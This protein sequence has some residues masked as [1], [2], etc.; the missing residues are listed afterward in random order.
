MRSNTTHFAPITELLKIHKDFIS[1]VSNNSVNILFHL[2]EQELAFTP[3]EHLIKDIDLSAICL[4]I[5]DYRA[6]PQKAMKLA[7]NALDIDPDS[8]SKTQDILAKKYR[9]LLF[10]DNRRIYV[11]PHGYVSNVFLT[12]HGRIQHLSRISIANMMS[13]LSTM[14]HSA[15]YEVDPIYA[16]TYMLFVVDNYLDMLRDSSIDIA[17]IYCKLLCDHACCENDKQAIT[18]KCSSSELPFNPQALERIGKLGTKL[19][20]LDNYEEIIRRCLDYK[21]DIFGSSADIESYRCEISN[22]SSP[23]RLDD[24]DKQYVDTFNKCLR[25]ISC[26][27][28]LRERQVGDLSKLCIFSQND[29][30]E[31]TFFSLQP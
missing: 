5:H 27:V 20:S 23:Y 3:A 9:C 10:R 18:L 8:R 7:Q 1:I 14:I 12:D 13:N 28:A 31:D 19:E 11:Q 16:D 26:M 15:Y 21:P 30:C 24:N 4:D 6:M 2:I 17:D 29:T 25:F 22:Q